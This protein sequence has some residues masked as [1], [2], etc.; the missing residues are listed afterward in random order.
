[1]VKLDAA[2]HSVKSWPDKAT[3]TGGEMR[4]GQALKAYRRYAGR[5]ASN[6]T[7]A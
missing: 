1:V 2:R 4:G 3:V 7:R 5:M 6:M